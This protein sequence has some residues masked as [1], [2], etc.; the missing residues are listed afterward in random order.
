MR[1]NMPLED[2]LFICVM[3]CGISYSDRGR[4]EHGD[5]KKVAFLPWSLVFEVRDPHSPLLK[6]A[7]ADAAKLQ[8]RRGERFTVSACGHT[9]VLGGAA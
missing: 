2:R 6:E 1:S 7:R 9:V 3:P 4:E 5:Y 8:A